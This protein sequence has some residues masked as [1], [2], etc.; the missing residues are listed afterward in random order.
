MENYVPKNPK[1]RDIPAGQ[2]NYELMLPADVAY[3]VD[4]DGKIV[5]RKTISVPSR[6]TPWERIKRKIRKIL[7]AQ[8]SQ[9]RAFSPKCGSKSPPPWN[10]SPT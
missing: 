1:L 9:P 8:P 7:S 6:L 10:G 4:K 3:R 5:R 2:V